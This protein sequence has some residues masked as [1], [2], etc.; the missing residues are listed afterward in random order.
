MASR[1]GERGVAEDLALRVYTTRLLGHDPK[2]VLHGGGNTS[3]KTRATDVLGEEHRVLRVKG[4]GWDMAYIEPE[5]LPAVKLGPLLKLRGLDRLSDE[6]MVNFERSNLMDSSAP[7]PSIETLLHAFLPD[8]FVD[9]THSTAVLSL[10][11]QPNGAELCGELF[12]DRVGIVPYVKPGF[13]L[14][15]TAGGVFDRTP[16]ADGLILLKHGIFT[17]A[18]S[19][20]EAYERMIE[21]VTLVEERLARG[22]RRVFRAASARGGAARVEEVAPILRG[23]CAL[24]D[25][26]GFDGSTRFILDFR[27]GQKIL[28]YV[29]GAELDRYS[30]AGVA[31]P[32]HTIRTKNWPMIAPFPLDGRLERFKQ[33]LDVA[34]ASYE[35]KCHAYFARHSARHAEP[36]IELDAV[37]RVVL[38]PGL[39]LFGLGR[40]AGD[41]LV[42]AD[43]AESTVETVADAESIGKFEA[44]GEAD[45]F[46]IEYW[47]LEQAKLGRSPEKPLRGCV[48]IVTGGGGAIGGA[49][50]AAFSREGAELA[51][52]DI[53]GDAALATRNRLGG[54]PLAVQC[55]VTDAGSVR[56]AFD[57]VCARFGGADIVVSNA[58]AAWQGRIG[59]VSDEVLRKSFE[60][61]FFAHQ[62]I[63][64][65]TVRIMRDQGTGGVLLFNVS[66][67]AVNPGPDF[68]PYGLPKAATLFLV[69]Q[70]ALDHARDGIRVNGVNA[71]RVR[72]GLLTSEMIAS[73]AAA[74]GVTEEAYMKGNLLGQEVSADDVAQAFVHQALEARTT[75]DITTVDGGNIAAALR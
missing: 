47:S 36:K 17:F 33:G 29:N 53:D 55:D 13:D 41:A 24:K 48:V 71:D 34:V 40:D 30:Q 27:T 31:T 14:A 72:G 52:L 57:A 25:G 8:K 60:L 32:D 61:N 56:A 5:G 26:G 1:L 46:D 49:T 66:K 28:D 21:L 44:A 73:R 23:A 58:G 16:D 22:R 70:Y 11:N 3:V 10:T 12:G 68:G 19:A 59:N 2:L 35:E 51:V 15:K 20:R 75:A 42:A 65:N 67:Q 50:A 43:I 45:L 64:Q 63:G 54:S 39:G 69:R 18:E 9:H 37:P 6:D 74:R 62:T 38:V 7:T 4:S